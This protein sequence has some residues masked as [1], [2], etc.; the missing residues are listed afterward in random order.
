MNADEQKAV[1]RDIFALALEAV[2]LGKPADKVISF[3]V[4]NRRFMGAN[5]RRYGTETRDCTAFVVT[6]GI[7]G[8][9]IP[10]KTGT[11]SEMVIIDIVGGQPL[12]DGL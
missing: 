8:W 1:A 9:A 3:E 4:K 7:S 6:S 5:D 12:R 2:K 11:F 10:F